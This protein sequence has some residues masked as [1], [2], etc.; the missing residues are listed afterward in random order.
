M[1]VDKK[2]KQTRHPGIAKP[3][4][5]I[6]RATE[7]LA[8]LASQSDLAAVDSA[9]KAHLLVDAWNVLGVGLLES[10]GVPRDSEEAWTALCHFHGELLATFRALSDPGEMTEVIEIAPDGDLAS[11]IQHYREEA[12]RHEGP[13]IASTDPRL[14]LDLSIDLPL[15]PGFIAAADHVGIAFDDAPTQLVQI[16][17]TALLFAIFSVPFPLARCLY[18]RRIFVRGTDVRRRFCSRDCGTRDADRMR[19][20]AADPDVRA[21]KRKMLRAAAQWQRDVVEKAPESSLPSSNKVAGQAQREPGRTSRKVR[22]RSKGG[23][24]A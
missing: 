19:R 12:L 10:Y 18:C 23:P 7:L 14:G 20:I 9:T 2:N 5:R 16:L 17:K 11:V 4:P 21:A 3:H 22:S 8:A 15:Q 24:S 1:S 6:L 13:A